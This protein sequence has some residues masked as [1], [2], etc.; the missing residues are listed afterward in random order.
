MPL[1]YKHMLADMQRGHGYELRTLVLSLETH[2]SYRACAVEF[3]MSFSA[4]VRGAVQLE[5]NR[6]FRNVNPQTDTTV[7]ASTR[8]FLQRRRGG[9]L[10][11]HPVEKEIRAAADALLQEGRRLD[12]DQPQRLMTSIFLPLDVI[13][14]LE[15]L[16]FYRRDRRHD[17]SSPLTI[18]AEQGILPLKEPRLP[19]VEPRGEDARARLRA[20]LVPPGSALAALYT[21]EERSFARD[22]QVLTGPEL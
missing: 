22:I 5:L 17:V 4:V 19:G 1:P 15:I 12:I 18:L 3:G 20:T 13:E 7:G 2:E 10:S 8:S 6:A 21:W 14:Q 16:R 11:G 9:A